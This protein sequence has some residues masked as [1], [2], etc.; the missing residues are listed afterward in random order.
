M[1]EL[2]YLDRRIEMCEI[3]REL[4]DRRLTNAAGGN[5]SE[6][7]E[8]NRVLITPSM[9]AEHKRCCLKPEDLMVIDYDGN[10]IEGSPDKLSRES[11][12]HTLCLR[13]FPEMKSVIHAHPQFTMVFAAHQRP[14]PSMTEAT[15]KMGECGVIEQAWAYS[16]ELAQKTYEY[17]LANKERMQKMGLQGILPLH[18]TV[19]IAPSLN[20]AFSIV[21]RVEYDAMA[22]IF[23]RF[24]E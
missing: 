7:V 11:R 15:M 8:E 12:M 21:E 6:R 24:T 13:N 18:G 4:W 14:I 19:A 2:K 10:I 22:K 9:M 23:G 20:K 16:A 1:N 5:V 3:V 17:F